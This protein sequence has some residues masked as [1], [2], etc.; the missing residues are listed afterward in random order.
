MQSLSNTQL[1]IISAIILLII[2]LILMNL[3]AYYMLGLIF[4]VGLLLTDEILVNFTGIERNQ[5]NYLS[6]QALFAL[7]FLVFN[8]LFILDNLH[9]PIHFLGIVI[10]VTFI[11]VLFFYETFGKRVIENLGEKRWYWVVIFS[12]LMLNFA[13]A[14]YH[15]QWRIVVWVLSF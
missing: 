5:I 3:G 13:S 11:L 12:V 9:Y 10:N 15:S 8:S 7:M 6:M 1:R 4:V 2:L 14:F